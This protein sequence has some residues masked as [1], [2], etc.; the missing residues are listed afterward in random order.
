MAGH[1]KLTEARS[2]VASSCT[3]PGPE[4]VS[5]VC[6]FGIADDTF[7][8]KEMILHRISEAE[9]FLHPRISL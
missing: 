2:L 9:I 7:P 1:S 4:P 3:S 8:V 5:I 6:L